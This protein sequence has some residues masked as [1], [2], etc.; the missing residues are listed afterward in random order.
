MS[1]TPP[2]HFTEL[3]FSSGTSETDEQCAHSNLTPNDENQHAQFS[4]SDARR[5]VSSI[6]NS[7]SVEQANPMTIL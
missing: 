7:G 5:N 4:C 1:C 6:H 3:S 2:Q